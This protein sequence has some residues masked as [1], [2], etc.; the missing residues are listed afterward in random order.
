MLPFSP[1]ISGN[2]ELLRD[3]RTGNFEGSI[4][5]TVGMHFETPE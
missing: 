1:A 3:H 2:K 4:N 5:T